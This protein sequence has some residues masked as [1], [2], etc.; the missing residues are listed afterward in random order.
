MATEEKKIKDVVII[1]M[2]GHAKVVADIVLASG[3]NIRGFLDK[4]DISDTFLGYPVLGTDE[5]YRQ[6]LDCYFVIAIGSAYVRKKIARL[7]SGVKWYTAI[8]PSAVISRIDAV[9]D[10]GTMIMANAVINSGAS[11]GRHCIINTQAVIEHD[12][13]VE[14]YAHISVGAKLAGA[15]HVGEG[16]HVGIGASVI[17]GKYVVGNSVVGAG[18]VVISDIQEPGTYVGVPAYKLK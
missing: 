5:E 11:I 13:I 1:G 12:D 9:I 18:A 6:F 7:L 16:T 4:S 10:E 14:D 8:H 2:G 17:E 15:V 3:D